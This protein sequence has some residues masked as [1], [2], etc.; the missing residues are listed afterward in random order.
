MRLVKRQAY[1]LSQKPDRWRGTF[2]SDR[3]G[4]EILIPVMGHRMKFLKLMKNVQSEESTTTVRPLED[5]ASEVEEAEKGSAST[6]TSR[7]ANT[8]ADKVVFSLC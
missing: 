5:S 3:K 8:T 7:A 6:W 1:I 4:S 2:K